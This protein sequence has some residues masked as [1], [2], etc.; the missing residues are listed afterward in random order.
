MSG[1]LD[2]IRNQEVLSAI[3]YW[4]RMLKQVEETEM[5][6][7]AL[8]D[9]HLTPALVQRGNMG[10]AFVEADPQLERV[11]EGTVLLKVD[12]ELVG[13]VGARVRHTVF[14]TRV[15]D[16]LKTAASDVVVAIE[17]AQSE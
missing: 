1:R 4:Q 12:D 17:K 11:A 13:H 6:A 7:R 9:L 10:P 5:G 15:L 2:N 8:V 14:I 16:A 3:I